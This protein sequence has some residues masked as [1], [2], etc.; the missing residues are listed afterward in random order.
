MV[1]YLTQFSQSIDPLECKWSRY[2]VCMQ[3]I[4][5]SGDV[6]KYQFPTSLLLAS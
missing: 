4:L 3:L 6:M 2:L 1:F 5:Q